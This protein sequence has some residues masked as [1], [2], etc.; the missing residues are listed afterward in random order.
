MHE[1]T[2]PFPSGRLPPGMPAS[3]LHIILT[4]PILAYGIYRYNRMNVPLKDISVTEESQSN[5]LRLYNE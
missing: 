4:I 2:Q 1:K 3:F 5:R